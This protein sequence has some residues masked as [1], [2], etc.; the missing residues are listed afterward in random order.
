MVGYEHY[1]RKVHP[2][3]CAAVPVH[4]PTGQVLGVIDVTGGPVVAS[5]VVMSLVRATVAAVEAELARVAA[6]RATREQPADRAHRAV[7]LDLM[8]RLRVLST[9]PTVRVGGVDVRLSLRHAEIL[10]LLARHPAGLSAD[11]LAVLLSEQMLSDVTV[12]AEVSRLRRIVGPLLSESRPVPADLVAAHGR[13]PGARAARGRRHRGRAV[14]LPA[15][16]CSRGR[17]RPGVERAREELSAELRAA[18]L[19]SPLPGVVSRWVASDEGADDW[20]A[21]ERLAWLAPRGTPAHVQAVGRLDLL[22]RRL[23]APPRRR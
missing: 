11:E 10:L 4:A 2:W 20:Q 15:A 16:R 7:D 9:G 1:A 12:R 17:S 23:G 14:E 22:G 19:A 5:A 18:V 13:R 6:E 21:W 3:N 8:P